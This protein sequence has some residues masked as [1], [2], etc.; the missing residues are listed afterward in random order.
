M[1]VVV[2][3]PGMLSRGATGL[4]W[5]AARGVTQ[6]SSHTFAQIFYRIKRQYLG[7]HA[8]GLALKRV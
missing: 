7:V 8:A 6:V 3:G 4:R 1:L 5:H 2:S